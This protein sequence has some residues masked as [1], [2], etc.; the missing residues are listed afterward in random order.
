[1]TNKTRKS[2]GCI[3]CP[4]VSGLLVSLQILW[5]LYLSK[6]SLQQ[7][8]ATANATPT[9]FDQFKYSQEV[10]EYSLKESVNTAK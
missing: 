1:M 10:N 3:T 4:R 2:C 5:D 7:L 9:E 6:T 8:H